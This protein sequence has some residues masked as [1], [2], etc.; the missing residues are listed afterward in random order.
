MSARDE[1]AEVDELT[2]ELL[3]RYEEINLLYDI[4][5][6]LAGVFDVQA[7]GRMVVDR[8]M[9]VTHAA[10]GAF[11]VTTAGAAT[12]AYRAG[13]I[14]D[15]LVADLVDGQMRKRVLATPLLVLQPLLAARVQRHSDV[16]A[17]IALTGKQDDAAFTAGDGRLLR[18]LAEQA[19]AAIHTGRL[20]RE[21]R[22]SER[23]RSELDIAHRL[24]QS[25]LPTVTPRV[26]GLALT[27]SCEPAGRVGGDYFDFF[28]LPGGALGLVIADVSG[29]G[30]SS[31]IVMAGLRATLHAEIREEF[32]PA[33][34]LA[35]ANRVLARDFGN[36]GMFVS[37]FLAKYEPDTGALTYTNAGHPPPLLASGDAVARLTSGGLVLGVA[38]DAVYDSGSATLGPGDMLVMYTDGLT[39]AR[40]NDGT[41]FGETALIR[42]LAAGD[43][44]DSAALHRAIL[45]AVS[46]HRGRPTPDD[47]VT[48][49][50][51]SRA[52]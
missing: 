25:L 7:I 31:A 9:A 8:A 23:I 13:H 36:S 47:D 3:D 4:A 18:A 42:M 32:A 27:G 43:Q 45:T 22:E 34:V 50:V 39:E 33:R 19:A 11:I 41:F 14:P 28:S 12:V 26:P 37:V 21:V 20:V 49:V 48:L 38:P 16:F 10:G 40:G 44:L 2:V 5:T 51:A 6:A 52:A 30:V 17:V 24:Q 29:H 35:V 46:D 15:A 1:S